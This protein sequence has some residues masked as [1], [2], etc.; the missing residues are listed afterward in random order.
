MAVT[1]LLATYGINANEAEPMI[2]V[3]H[4]REWEGGREL[5]VECK[6]QTCRRGCFMY[7]KN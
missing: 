1:V 5:V 6:R 4:P 2:M 3:G 7:E